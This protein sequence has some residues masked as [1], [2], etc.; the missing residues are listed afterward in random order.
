[1]REG[2]L[3]NECLKLTQDVATRWNST[4]D[5]LE[6]FV[7]LSNAIGAALLSIVSREH[8]PPPMVSAAELA[9]ATLRG[10]IALQAPL[11]RVTI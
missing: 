9:T 4:L 5:K 7:Q 2:H 6:R 3:E 10:L 1:M 8:P 11:Q